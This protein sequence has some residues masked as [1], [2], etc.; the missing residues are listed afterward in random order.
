M[1]CCYLS[2]P[3]FH[4]RHG[5][6]VKQATYLL[7]G[8]FVVSGR[9]QHT[10]VAVYRHAYQDNCALLTERAPEQRLERN[11]HYFKLMFITEAT[12]GVGRFPSVAGVCSPDQDIPRIVKSSG[13]W[14]SVVRCK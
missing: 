2:A 1:L 7:V 5:S 9:V 8:M 12:H 3:K 14:R 13:I 11:K 4:A 10:H 6:D